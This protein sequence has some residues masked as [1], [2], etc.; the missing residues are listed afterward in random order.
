MAEAR[1][2]SQP[3]LARERVNLRHAAVDR[4]WSALASPL[5]PPA[6]LFVLAAALAADAF[7]ALAVVLLVLSSIAGAIERFPPVL[8][9]PGGAAR[10]GPWLIHAG[11][12]VTV[13]GAAVARLFAV[14]GT[15]QVNQGGGAAGYLAVRE[16]DGSEGRVP[17]GFFVHC[18]DLRVETFDGDRPKW[19]E[20]DLVLRTDAGGAPGPELLR[21]T[22]AP[23][24]PLRAGSAVL[25]VAG[26]QR[27]EP[28]PRARLVVLDSSNGSRHERLLARGES[29][30]AGG[31]R[32]TLLGP[33]A[34][35]ESVDVERTRQG[36]SD[37]ISLAARKG[38]LRDGG[39]RLSFRGWQPLYAVELRIVRDFTGPIA[40]AGALLA[41]AGVALVASGWRKRSG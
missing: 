3:A 17:I 7:V 16:R 5:G 24:R 41:L 33:S 6:L 40:S 25:Q 38:D 22:V 23:G 26:Y 20:A 30:D 37:R 35:R 4:C 18:T 13:G 8:W 34:D 11:V 31:A 9:A 19:F 29:I 15:T 39:V 21:E 14:E 12:V 28:Q 1:I 10:F 36:R 27:L 2:E 32:Y